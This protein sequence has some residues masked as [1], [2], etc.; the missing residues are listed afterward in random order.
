M[1]GR[2]NSVFANG[3]PSKK[4]RSADAEKK[5]A[6]GKGTYQT[7]ADVCTLLKGTIQSEVAKQRKA[8]E[9]IAKLARD[10]SL[11]GFALASQ[12]VY[13]ERAYNQLLHGLQQLL[14]S[15]E[16]DCDAGAY[17]ERVLVLTYISNDPGVLR[18][19]LQLDAVRM[20]YR[21]AVGATLQQSGMATYVGRDQE[22]MFSRAGTILDDDHWRRMVARYLEVT[23]EVQENA[24]AVTTAH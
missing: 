8:T 22:A 12:V 24:V 4:M 10:P 3:L 9:E 20:Q 17:D 16:V 15:Y 13:I 6:L 14:R 21:Q 23:P 18:R 7:F 1:T 2:I 11:S 5:V 19:S